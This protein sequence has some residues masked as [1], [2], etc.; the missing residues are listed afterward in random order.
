MSYLQLSDYFTCRIL[1]PC[2]KVF[3]WRKKNQLKQGRLD[4]I[5]ISKNVSNL[6]ELF[7]IRT[8]YRSDH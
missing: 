4:Y 3:T 5:F 7:S 6:V 2:K 8:D 1:N